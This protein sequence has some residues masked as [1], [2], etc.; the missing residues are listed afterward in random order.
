MEPSGGWEGT[1]GAQKHTPARTAAPL[2]GISSRPSLGARRKPL[3][4]DIGVPTSISLPVPSPGDTVGG[5]WGGGSISPLPALA[6]ELGC[7]QHFYFKPHNMYEEA[8]GVR[9]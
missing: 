2:A 4:S 5:R 9:G 1:G 6:A 8:R 7:S 3:C